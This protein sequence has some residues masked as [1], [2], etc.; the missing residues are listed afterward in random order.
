MWFSWI[1][2]YTVAHCKLFLN[3]L[4]LLDC[5]SWRW[6]WF[7]L[8]DMSRERNLL[9]LQKLFVVMFTK[10]YKVEIN[11]QLT[12]AG[13]CPVPCDLEYNH[14]LDEDTFLLQRIL[15]PRPGCRRGWCG[16]G[17]GAPGGGRPPSREA[18]TLRE[19]VEN[20]LG[21][22]ACHTWDMRDDCKLHYYLI[23]RL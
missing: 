23:N 10:E 5:K 20:E 2:I 6:C 9:F 21:R 14:L 18:A 1:T 11:F 19:W 7:H 12:E 22:E 17:R 4:L 8:E 3:H 13:R 16:R 15:D